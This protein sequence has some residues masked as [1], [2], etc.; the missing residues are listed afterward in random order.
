MIS[1]Q[2]TI[3][4][5]G[6]V[7]LLLL[8]TFGR[9]LGPKVFARFSKRKIPYPSNESYHVAELHKERGEHSF[10]FRIFPDREVLK[11]GVSR[12]S[13][14]KRAIYVLVLIKVDGTYEYT[15]MQKQNII[16]IP[17]DWRE[18]LSGFGYPEKGFPQH[19]EMDSL[20]TYQVQRRNQGRRNRPGHPQP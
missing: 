4:E 8:A 15:L 20:Y 13:L 16:Q 5:Y 9:W 17:H 12:I 10:W 11:A 7:G 14:S 1:M 18:L 3:F 19:R 6:L 2:T